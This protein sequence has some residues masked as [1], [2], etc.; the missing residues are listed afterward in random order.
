M[1][2]ALR[3]VNDDDA[4]VLERVGRGDAAALGVAF[5]RWHGDVFAL[6]VRLRGSRWAVEDLVQETFVA[7]PAAARNFTAG[8]SPRAF[9]MGVALHLARRERRKVAR[10]LALWRAHGQGLDELVTHADP[11]RD[12]EARQSLARVSRALGSLPEAQREAVVLVELE[13]L[14]G[15][16]AA[17]AMGVPVNTVWTRLHYARAA[18]RDAVKKGGDR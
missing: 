12:A 15:D 5:D 10:R 13:G 1:K 6:L 11:E 16:E 14:S 9:V 8:H 7:L 4:A 18:L 2:P 3:P 17:A